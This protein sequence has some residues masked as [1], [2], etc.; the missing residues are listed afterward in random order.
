V[1]QIPSETKAKQKHNSAETEAQ[2]Q[3]FATKTVNG[4]NLVNAKEVDHAKQGNN[5]PAEIAE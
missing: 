4:D 3:H 2:K 1:K 5:H